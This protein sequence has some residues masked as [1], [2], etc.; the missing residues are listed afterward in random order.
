MTVDELERRLHNWIRWHLHPEYGNPLGYAMSSL[1]R[2]ASEGFR[3]SAVPILAG[4]A[5]DFDDA[6]NRLKA[7][8]KDALRLWHLHPELTRQEQAARAGV[9]VNTL[10]ERVRQAKM[11][12]AELATA[13][14]TNRN[15]A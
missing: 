2:A 5:R 6:V 1:T 10:R 11:D 9:H 4:E 12:L 14:Y 7:A 8:Q 3:T 13:R 15:A